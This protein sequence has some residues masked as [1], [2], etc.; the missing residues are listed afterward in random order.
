MR[1]KNQ[2][3]CTSSAV[4]SKKIS[5]RFEIGPFYFLPGTTWPPWNLPHFGF[6]W[7]W[8][9]YRRNYW[10]MWSAN[11]S[12]QSFYALHQ[13]RELS[14]THHPPLFFYKTREITKNWI[15]LSNGIYRQ[16]MPASF[17][18]VRTS[19]WAPVHV[20]GLMCVCFSIQVR[21][22]QW[23]EIAL[24]FSS[25]EVIETK[26]MLV[27]AYFCKLKE[28]LEGLLLAISIVIVVGLWLAILG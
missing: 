28:R 6:K 22:F 23:R 12:F 25:S 27:V 13:S 14:L 16:G 10:K 3:I 1:K 5:W 4:I 2:P 18:S 7:L 15:F 11:K 26:V 21:G 17:S 20:H 24:K 19:L 9:Q 8:L